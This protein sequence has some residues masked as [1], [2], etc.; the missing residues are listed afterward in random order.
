MK[1]FQQVRNETIFKFKK[2][3]LPSLGRTEFSNLELLP[4]TG[5]RNQFH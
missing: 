4:N 3:H 2:V 5:F 1:Q